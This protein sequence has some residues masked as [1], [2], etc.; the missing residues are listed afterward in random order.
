MRWNPRESRNILA[1]LLI[2]PSVH[3]RTV[4]NCLATAVRLKRFEAV[5]MLLAW[6]RY[7]GFEWKHPKIEMEKGLLHQACQFATTGIVKL[8]VEHRADVNEIYYDRRPLDLASNNKM[9]KWL[10]TRGAIKTET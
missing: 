3:A 6:K 4:S 2:S 10:K 7:E 9:R 1:L 5:K 8:L